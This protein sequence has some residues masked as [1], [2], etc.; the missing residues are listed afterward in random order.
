MKIDALRGTVRY[1]RRENSYL[2]GQDLLKEIRS[3]PPIPDFSRPATPELDRS[4]SPTDSDSDFDRPRTPTT[5]NDLATEAS[6]LYREVLNFSS[7]PRVVDLS[8]INK[9]RI[10][11]VRGGRG[12][13]SHSPPA[14]HSRKR[15]TKAR[16]PTSRSWFYRISPCSSTSR[17]PWAVELRPRKG[18]A[19]SVR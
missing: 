16:I 17:S 10:D 4:P 15:L 8:I 1:I 9:K 13:M 14:S 2:K 12:W 6:V 11:P 3:L 7:S 19:L 5:L 18:R